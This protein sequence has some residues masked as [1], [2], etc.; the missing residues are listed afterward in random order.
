MREFY[1]AIWP[2]SLETFGPSYIRDP[3]GPLDHLVKE[4][5]E[6]LFK[7]QNSLYDL[8]EYADLVF[9]V[10]DACHRAGYSYDQLIEMCWRKFMKNLRRTWP[11]W[12]GTYPTKAVEHDRSKD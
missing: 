6:E 2:W 11:D 3:R 8:E 9:L 5:Q 12:R 10:F 7:D 4:V 1:N